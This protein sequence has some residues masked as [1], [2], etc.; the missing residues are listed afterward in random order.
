MKQSAFTPNPF[1]EAAL[2]IAR[3]KLSRDANPQLLRSP[4]LGTG[5]DFVNIFLWDTA[6]SV[7]WAK[8][9][10]DEFPVADSLDNFYALQFPDG[11]ISRESCPDGTSRWAPECP[12]AFAPPLLAWAELDLYEG[13]FITTR[14]PEVFPHLLAQYEYNKAHF[15]RP[16]GLYY[17][18]MLGCGMDD[19]PR[20]NSVSDLTPEGGI[21]LTRESIT[22]P[23]EEREK[24]YRWLR[25]IPHGVCDWNRQIGWCETTAQSA[26][27]ALCLARIAHIIGESGERRGCWRSMRNLPA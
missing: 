4:R 26:F 6:F 20:W 9:H 19:M 13:G 24:T 11:F 22:A 21:P 5:G 27:F 18:D 14:L 12:S 2:A 23:G 25:G 1:Y 16:D 8:F 15:R 10:A 3:R 7:Q 17:T